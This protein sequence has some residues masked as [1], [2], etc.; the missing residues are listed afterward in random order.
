M[1]FSHIWFII[2]PCPEPVS[3][4][5]SSKKLAGS[6]VKISIPICNFISTFSSSLV[7]KS[8]FI[9]IPGVGTRIWSLSFFSNV[10]YHCG[11]LGWFYISGNF[12][13]FQG[14]LGRTKISR[15]KCCRKAHVAGIITAF[16]VD[17]ARVHQNKNK[18][19][20]YWVTSKNCLSQ[21]QDSIK[22]D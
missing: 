21:C 20:R 13:K 22:S 17:S 7:S 15:N 12:R 3:S 6:E 18:Q 19:V 16:N 1:N 2:V 8:I 14:G 9:A 5:T 10:W 4:L 11:V